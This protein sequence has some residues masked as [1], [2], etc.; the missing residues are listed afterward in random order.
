MRL[1]CTIF[2]GAFFCYCGIYIKIGDMK[3]VQNKQ[4]LF[5]M[6]GKINPGYK[7]VLNEEDSCWDGYKQYGMKDK[8]GK[9]VPNCVPIDEQLPTTQY[10]VPADVAYLQ[11]ATDKSA[12]VKYAASRI[13]TPQEFQDGFQEWLS[14]TGFNPQ[15]KTNKYLTSTD[16]SKKCN[17]KIRI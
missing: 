16:I 12:S 1:K 13:D 7:T 9:E 15:K 11:K 8:E 10:K 4:K 2:L 17:D 3:N 5:E 6:M 14:T